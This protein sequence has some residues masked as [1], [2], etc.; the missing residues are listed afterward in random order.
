MKHFQK[1]KKDFP[2]INTNK[3]GCNMVIKQSSIY[4]KLRS[5]PNITEAGWGDFGTIFSHIT[6]SHINP[7]CAI[8]IRKEAGF[9]DHILRGTSLQKRKKRK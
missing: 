7:V 9:H 5:G 6:Q 4:F 1:K 3:N 8:F 2:V